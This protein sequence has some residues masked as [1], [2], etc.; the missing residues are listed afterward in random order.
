MLAVPVT[1]EQKEVRYHLPANWP[2]A[3]A[4]ALVRHGYLDGREPARSWW[5]NANALGGRAA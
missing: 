2:G 1:D 3:R 4:L 5:R